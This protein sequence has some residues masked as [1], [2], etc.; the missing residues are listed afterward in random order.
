[1]TLPM[2]R[3]AAHSDDASVP[4][5]T[6]MASRTWLR[7]ITGGGQI[8]E[9]C[10]SWCVSS[11][12]NDRVGMLDNLVHVGEGVSLTM[13]IFD[14]WQDE[15]PVTRV[16]Q[17]LRADVRVD[18]YSEN[19]R[20]NVPFVVFEPWGDEGLDEVN[21]EE[22]AALIARLRAHADRLE[23]VHTQLVAARAE[24]PGAPTAA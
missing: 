18:P 24:H 23:Q 2:R 3:T 9:T 22:F 6:P 12:V 21:P 4:T 17:I 16:E 15:Q 10:P 13:E 11:H 8:V 14:H 20:R 7:R 5:V 1:M 19:P